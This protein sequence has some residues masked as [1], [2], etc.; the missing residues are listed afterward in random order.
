MNIRYITGFALNFSFLK[1]SLV[2]LRLLLFK[3]TYVIFNSSFVIL[4]YIFKSFSKIML[5]SL[6]DIHLFY[7]NTLAF[8]ELRY[9][10]EINSFK[11]MCSLKVD[12][13]YCPPV[14]TKDFLSFVR[15]I[16]VKSKLEP[17]LPTLTEIC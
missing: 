17:L 16:F 9:C 14:I 4:L 1:K 8:G 2:V 6:I 5:M 10:Y 12:Y 7:K 13:T 15:S 3:H 11:R